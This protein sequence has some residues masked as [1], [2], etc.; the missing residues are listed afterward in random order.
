MPDDEAT[1]STIIEPALMESGCPALVL[2]PGDLVIKL[3]KSV[4]AW[5][6]GLRNTRRHV[7]ASEYG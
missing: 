5:N 2:P 6:G 1:F 7:A 3:Q 4:I